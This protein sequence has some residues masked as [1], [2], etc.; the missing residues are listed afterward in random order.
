MENV[1]NDERE[2]IAYIESVKDA[3]NRRETMQIEYELMADELAKRR[4]ER[5]QVNN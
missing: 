2:Y 4:A 5:D 3:L 1:P